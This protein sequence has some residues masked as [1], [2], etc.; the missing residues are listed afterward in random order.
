MTAVACH[1]AIV[2]HYMIGV[3]LVALYITRFFAPNQTSRIHIGI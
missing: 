2:A 3:V 1:T